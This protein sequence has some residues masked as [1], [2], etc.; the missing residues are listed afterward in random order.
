VLLAGGLLSWVLLV[1]GC[2]R[3]LGGAPGWFQTSHLLDRQQALLELAWHGLRWAT[4]SVHEGPNRAAV[5]REARRAGIPVGLALAVARAESG[6]HCYRVSATGAMGLMQLMPATARELEVGDAFDAQQNAAGG[7]RYLA[8]LLRRYGGEASRAVA[9]Y[10][11]GPGRVARR[12]AVR[13]PA[14]TRSYVRKV[15]T[16]YRGGGAGGRAWVSG[17]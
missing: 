8:Q 3:E 13:L 2:V 6:M 10:N 12:G 7:S 11:A 14:E 17:D 5:R 9:A 15:M 1:N 4:G 16:L